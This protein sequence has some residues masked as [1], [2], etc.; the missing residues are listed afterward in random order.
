[1]LPV[2][3][4]HQMRELWECEECGSDNATHQGGRCTG[5]IRR[6]IARAKESRMSGTPLRR[7][8][9]QHPG[10]MVM[11]ETCG[12]HHPLDISFYDPAG[13][14]FNSYYC[15]KCRPCLI[16]EKEEYLG[17]AVVKTYRNVRRCMGRVVYV[18]DEYDS[19]DEALANSERENEEWLREYVARKI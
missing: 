11:C 17:Y 5:C 3:K 8:S 9:Q 10:I 18:G 16:E 7:C 13:H 12:T 6:S 19:P 14:E 1:M 2:R 15:E 4:G